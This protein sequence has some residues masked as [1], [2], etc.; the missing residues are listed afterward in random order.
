VFNKTGQY[1]VSLTVNNQGSSST[2]TRSG[3]ITVN[4]SQILE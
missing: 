1:T 3:Y 4:K 2:E